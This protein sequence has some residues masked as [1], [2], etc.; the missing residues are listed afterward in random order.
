MATAKKPNMVKIKLFKDNK[1]YTSD[2]FVGVNGRTYQIQRG[3]EVEV[4]DYVAEVLRNSEKQDLHA[5]MMMEELQ[6][7]ADWDSK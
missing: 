7:D 1:N 2:V 3:V 5:V 4:P 6:K